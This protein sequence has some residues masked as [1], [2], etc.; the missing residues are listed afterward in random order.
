MEKVT[1]Q[2]VDGGCRDGCR[3]ENDAATARLYSRALLSA[4]VRWAW[5]RD[6]VVRRGG[7]RKE[8]DEVR[9]ESIMIPSST[10]LDRSLTR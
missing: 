1:Q 9:T 7:G 10:A 5:R 2:K 8:R 4:M 6:A 3:A